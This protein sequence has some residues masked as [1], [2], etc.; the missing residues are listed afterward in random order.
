MPLMLKVTVDTCDSDCLRLAQSRGFPCGELGLHG[1]RGSLVFCDAGVASFCVG[2]RVSEFYPKVRALWGSLAQRLER[3]FQG[4]GLVVK[5]VDI[6]VILPLP[7]PL[8]KCQRSS[9]CRC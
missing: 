7:L 5:S 4:R 1:G 8:L 9:I 2:V 3:P 6:V